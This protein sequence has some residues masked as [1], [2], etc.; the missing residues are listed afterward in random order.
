[1]IFNKNHNGAAELKS[2]LGFLY[3]SNTFANIATDVML[4][5]EDLAE[6]ISQA[7]MEKAETHYHSA[8][9]NTGAQYALLDKLVAH[10]Q[11]PVAYYAYAA[12]AAHT[13]VSHGDDGR[14][15]VIDSENQK[16]AWEWMI[17][18]DEDAVINKAHKTTD[19]LIS[20]LEKNAANI[21]EWKDSEARKTANGLI[22]PT[23]KVF[24]QIFPIDNSSRFFITIIPFIAEAQRKHILPV[25]GPVRYKD[26]VDALK[27]GTYTDAD[28]M[29]MLL[30]VPLA[31]F[32][33]SLAV[34]RLSVRILPNGIFQDYVSDTLSRKAKQPADADTRNAVAQ[35]LYNDAT[36]ELQNLQ[37]T[38]AKLDADAA[39]I[40][41]TPPSPSD[42][43]KPDN[44]IFRL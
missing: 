16:M 6:I 23:A 3:A 37:K 32:S 35:M 12:Y 18:R 40:D 39:N 26:V 20:F 17:D 22:I 15:V 33:L 25:L 44:K 8:N 41:Y 29:L 7:V 38:I 34:K 36:F 27:A 1:M 30:R 10:I 11:L 9:Y 5:Q 21:T 31:Y 14:K 43:I 19:R 4:A 13:D 42:Y 2:L 24:N 28:N